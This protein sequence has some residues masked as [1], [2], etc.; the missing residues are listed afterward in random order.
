MAMVGNRRGA[1]LLAL[2]GIALLA[3]CGTNPPSDDS[4]LVEPLV[5]DEGDD[6]ELVEPLVPAGTDAAARYRV[7]LTYT[8]R[9]DL[10]ALSGGIAAIHEGWIEHEDRFEGE[11]QAAGDGRWEGELTGRAEGRDHVSATAIGIG[12]YTCDSS[13]DAT[14]D[15]D[16][17][18][19]VIEDDDDLSRLVE[20]PEPGAVYASITLDS[21][22]TVDYA[23]A[24]DECDPSGGAAGGGEDDLSDLIAP[25]G[26]TASEDW[27]PFGA[28]SCVHEGMCNLAVMLP[29]SGFGKVVE[30]LDQSLPG[31]STAEWVFELE[32]VD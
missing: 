25:L 28:Y 11:V 16:L 4:D 31:V 9:D 21:K 6:S 12:D 20:D 30:R 3:A 19:T 29:P 5:P 8:S 15:V 24:P 2:A 7:V 18:L 17:T 26:P 13:W 22:G 27:A 14:Q 10:G 32:A 1:R 23:D